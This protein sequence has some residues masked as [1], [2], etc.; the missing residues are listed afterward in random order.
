MKLTKV[1]Y[2]VIFKS[3]LVFLL[4]S[5]MVYAGQTG[6]ISGYIT[7]KETGEPIF[8]ANVVVE[9]TYFGAACDLEGYYFINNVT[10]GKYN[11]IVS[12]IGYKKTTIR[13]VNVK[14]DLTTSIDVELI[15]DVLQLGEEVVI[16][17]EKP[18]IQRDLTSTS[19]TV[20]SD[21]I[22]MIPVENV[23]Q[24][25]N[26]Q[27]G[28]MDGHFRGGRH[29]EVAYL[30]DGISVTDAYNGGMAVE[31]ENNSIRQLEVISGTFNAEY[32][33]ALSG[34]VN[35]VTK[36]GS[37]TEYEGNVSAF[38]G[39]YLTSD[40]ELF[41]NADKLSTDG[42]K[43]VQFSLSGP[44][45]ILESLTFF[46]TG[47]Y[48]SDR[49]HLYGKR[50]Y[51]S[52]DVS[53]YLPTGDGE[54]VP[55]N[56]SEKKSFNGK[57]TYSVP[58]WKFSYSMFYD[59]SWNKYYDHGY[60]WA[61]DG[62][63]NH[64]KDN[65]IHNLQI[66][67][68]PSNSTY[69][70]LKASSNLHKFYG[71]LYKNDFDPNYLNPNHGIPTSAYTYRYGG[72]QANRYNRNTLTYIGQFSI[73]SQVSKEHK[74]KLGAETR[75]HDMYDHGRDIVNITEGQLDDFGRE[76]FTLGYRNEHTSGNQ[77][78]RKYPYEISAFI[79]DKMEYDIM[80]INLGLRYDY[81]NSNST[82]PADI[83][84]PLNNKD[85]PG[86]NK[87]VA[88]EAESQISP[89]L[90]VSFPITDKGAI[91]FSYGHFLQIPRFQNLYLNDEYIISQ[92]QALSSVTGNP[93]LKVE[94][95]V[96]YE[97]GLQ[98]VIFPNVSLDLTVYYSDIRNL[99]GMEIINT[100]EGFKYAR[101]T[102]RD[103]GNIKG[104]IVSF[105][106]RF[107]DYFSAKLDYTYQIAEGNASDP[108]AV[109]NNNQ[110][111]PPIETE[112]KT[113]PLDWDQRSTLNITAN[114][115]QPGDWMLGFIFSY[116][117]GT[118]Y[119]E[120][121]K[122]SNG[123]RFEN[124]GRKP[125]YINLDFRADKYFTVYGL[126]LHAFLWVYNLLDIQNEVGVYSTTGRADQNLDIKYAGD[127]E[128]LNTIDEYVMNPTFYST[129]R[130]VRVGFSVG[131]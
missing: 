37:P 130:Q 114:A 101:F 85:F 53:P 70:S 87:T 123:V 79:Q 49:G 61:P 122:V 119:T 120:D 34:V 56:P 22:S 92:G 18:L 83:R 113:V 15:P 39:N 110:S 86:Y 50:I 29:G 93:N 111:D 32:G 51:N 58:E 25:V 16:Q 52:Y 108:Y 23:Q 7:D 90:G 24:V 126:D 81:F 8:G 94:R 99:L 65:A 84:N 62:L 44:T 102:N 20:S 1:W 116:G 103:Y 77:S 98:Q 35:I 78:Y 54:Y 17:A 91:Y 48:Y 63:L 9:G 21:D 4:L 19:V 42:P 38:I 117:S 28:V 5:G 36:E 72:N 107:A 73:E 131:F 75:F 105:D 55:M 13:D 59:K 6:K 104:F 31:V 128:G 10:P 3:L 129:P 89:R 11:V 43:D 14:I 57:I 96:Q 47:R 71:H 124:G 74:V 64:Y 67:Y 97:V 69:L 118:P 80:I 76:I 12:A 112:K 106:K 109:Y 33:Q 30:V 82:L 100:Y 45:K 40:S 121:I 26:L 27:A 2:Y 66:F 60:R 125:T 115:G 127:I 88:S 95:R 46:M 68:Y 41:P